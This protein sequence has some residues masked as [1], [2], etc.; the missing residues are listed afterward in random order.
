MA[1]IHN[2]DIQGH[3]RDQQLC[4]FLDGEMSDAEMAE[5]EDK[6]TTNPELRRR[7]EQFEHN[8]VLLRASQPDAEQT[9]TPRVVALLSSPSREHS[10]NSNR[11]WFKPLSAAA[12][13]TLA[14]GLVLAMALNVGTSEPDIPNMDRNL[15]AALDTLPSRADGWDRLDDGRSLRAVL[16]FPAADGKWCREFLVASQETH[17]RG[18]ACR[19]EDT[20]VT[21]ILGRELYVDTNAGYRTASA[22]DNDAI[23]R[24]VDQNATG[25]ALSASEEQGLISANWDNSAL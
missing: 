11:S 7:L 20:W 4:R 5:F 25:I 2:F 22:S 3:Q 14:F 1:E 10:F 19:N 18:V 15:V 6:L 12:S 17:W 21:Q 9:V 16:T 13:I 23:A 24:F 8:D